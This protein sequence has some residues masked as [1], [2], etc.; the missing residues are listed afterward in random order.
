MIV[1]LKNSSGADAKGEYSTTTKQ[2]IVKKGSVVSKTVSNANFRGLK[3]IVRNRE[4]FVKNGIVIK[5]VPFNSPSTAANFVT[6]HSSN[7]LTR[8]KDQTGKNLKK[9]QDN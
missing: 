1:Y 7:G 8:W 9:Y 2:L 4:L 5:D 3:S 6:G